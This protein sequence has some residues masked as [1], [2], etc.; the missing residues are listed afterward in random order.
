MR[1]TTTI[2]VSPGNRDA[3]RQLADFDGVTLDEE[4][5]R[6]LRAERQRR[7]GGQLGAAELTGSDRAWL[8]LGIATA[9]DNARR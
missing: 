5:A 4:I 9:T 7:M 1:E 6:L 8:D 2:R 3:L